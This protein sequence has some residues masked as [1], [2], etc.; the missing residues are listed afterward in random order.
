MS[1]F[2]IFPNGSQP[3][4]W[5]KWEAKLHAHLTAAGYRKFMDQHQRQDY[6]YW[7]MVRINDQEAYQLGC[8]VYDF[9][10]H[11]APSDA[12]YRI[13][14][15]YICM[16]MGEHRIDL[17]VSQPIEVA[18]FEQMATVFYEALKRFV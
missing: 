4:N 12:G 13:S 10:K 1:T 5:H 11:Y 9:R 16:L 3:T 18:Q 15:M 14:F 8:M 17:K 7:K 2:Q 6:S